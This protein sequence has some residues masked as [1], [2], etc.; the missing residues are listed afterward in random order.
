M[1]VFISIRKIN[2]EVKNLFID[3]LFYS[4]QSKALKTGILWSYRVMEN[5]IFM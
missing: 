5:E 3:V 2:Y 1:N 4:V